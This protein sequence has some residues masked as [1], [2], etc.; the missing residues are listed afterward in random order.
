MGLINRQLTARGTWPRRAIFLR[1]LC[2]SSFDQRAIHQHFAS[3]SQVRVLCARG[4]LLMGAP[5]PGEANRGPKA[6]LGPP[7]SMRVAMNETWLRLVFV[8]SIKVHFSIE[9]LVFCVFGVSPH[10]QRRTGSHLGSRKVSGAGDSAGGGAP[11]LIL[12]YF[13]T[14]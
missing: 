6:P 11:M 3:P 9:T 13:F 8:L 4:A 2:R 10:I 1:A 12:L 5:A 7:L 14:L